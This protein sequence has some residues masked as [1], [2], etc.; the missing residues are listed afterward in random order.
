MIPG[1]EHFQHVQE[2]LATEMDGADKRR[3]WV[4]ILGL[5]PRID[6]NQVYFLWGDDLASGVAGFGNNA[7][8]AMADFDRAMYAA[9]A[10]GTP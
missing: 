1:S 9:N 5:T 3:E 10:R 4:V 2:V 6:G 7:I 8:E